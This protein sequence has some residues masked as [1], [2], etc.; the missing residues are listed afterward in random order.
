MIRSLRPNGFRIIG[1]HNFVRNYILLMDASLLITFIG[2]A[3]PFGITFNKWGVAQKG[4][5]YTF[6]FR[7]LLVIFDVCAFNGLWGGS[8]IIRTNLWGC[9]GA[10]SK[11]SIKFSSFEECVEHL[12]KDALKF[13]SQNGESIPLELQ[14]FKEAMNVWFNSSF[15]GKFKVFREIT[16]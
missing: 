3:I 6:T 1:L 16:F 10:L 13:I 4:L 9:G 7:K 14:H 12:W 5:R 2:A 11:S 8:T 15:E